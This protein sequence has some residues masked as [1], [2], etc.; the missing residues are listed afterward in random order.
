M[1]EHRQRVPYTF[2]IDVAQGDFDRYRQR[3]PNDGKIDN[4]I[5]FFPVNT[6]TDLKLGLVAD[7]DPI[8]E[9]E[10]VEGTPDLSNW[11]LG[12]GTTY[13]FDVEIEVFENDLI[14]VDANNVS[15]TSDLDAFVSFT[16]E[17]E[18]GFF[19]DGGI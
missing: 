11:I 17:F 4:I 16:V 8:N 13:E 7:S 1:S 2:P 14:G 18:S 6:R 15:S 3:L 10:G 5:V 19:D 9:A 12:S